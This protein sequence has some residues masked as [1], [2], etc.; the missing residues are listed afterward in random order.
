MKTRFASFYVPT[1]PLTD[2]RI[3]EYTSEF[4]RD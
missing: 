4:S 2:P 1:F 3:S